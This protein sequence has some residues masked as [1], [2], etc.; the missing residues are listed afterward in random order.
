MN[1][2][3]HALMYS[4]YGIRASRIMKVPNVLAMV[5]TTLQTL[6]MVVGC[7]I[8]ILAFYY[9]SSGIKFIFDFLFCYFLF[10][11]WKMFSQLSK[12][13]LVLPHVHF[14]LLSVCQVNILL[15]QLSI[16][17]HLNA[18]SFTFLTSSLVERNPSR[19]INILSF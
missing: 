12:L 14:I 18:G 6:Q 5:I 9:L 10:W 13:A 17:I 3:V 7:T 1:Y 2:A 15:L 19:K 11:R 16:I 4:Y 8:N